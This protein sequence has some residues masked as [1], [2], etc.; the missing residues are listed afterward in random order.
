MA[1]ADAA[2]IRKATIEKRASAGY[3]VSAAAVGASYSLSVYLTGS[4]GSS[5][6][7]PVVVEVEDVGAPN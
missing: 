4:A 2:S 7:L 6:D 5:E 1:Q 3:R